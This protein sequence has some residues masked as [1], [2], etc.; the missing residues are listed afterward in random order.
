ME[1]AHVNSRS[2]FKQRGRNGLQMVL[3]GKMMHFVI[4]RY[5]LEEI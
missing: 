2:D 4:L 3:V 5:Y 1:K